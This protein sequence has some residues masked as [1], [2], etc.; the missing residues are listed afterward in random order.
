[1]CRHRG[2]APEAWGL[3]SDGSE[4][5]GQ[6]GVDVTMTVLELAHDY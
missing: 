3:E 1:M 4:N 2:N 5:E 6:E